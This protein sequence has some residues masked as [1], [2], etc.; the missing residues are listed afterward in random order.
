PSE[1]RKKKSQKYAEDEA[2][3]PAPVPQLE[4]QSVGDTPS[5]SPLANADDS[6]LGAGMDL[7][8]K[9]KPTPSEPS[10][11]PS[12]SSSMQTDLSLS[13]SKKEGGAKRPSEG[14]LFS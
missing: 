11:D 4:R 7:I 2:R 13:D 14:N 3:V 5:S 9:R 1:K 12:S 10:R 6:A 8:E